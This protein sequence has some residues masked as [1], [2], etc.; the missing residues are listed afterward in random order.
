[1][2]LFLVNT[3]TVIATVNAALAAAVV[4]LAVRKAHAPATIAVVT[5]AAA[6]L[7]VWAALV[8]WE[9]RTLDP[10]ARTT[11]RFPTPPDHA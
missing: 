2:G 5:A 11:P 6:F 9:R 4:V 8:A 3:P 7:L 10:V 1:V